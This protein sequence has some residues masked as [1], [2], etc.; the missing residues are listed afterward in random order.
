MTV[1]SILRFYRSVSVFSI[2]GFLSLYQTCSAATMPQD[3]AEGSLPKVHFLR[4]QE[5]WSVLKGIPSSQLSRHDHIKFIALDSQDRNWLSLGG[6]F[7][8]RAENWSNFAFSAPRNNDDSF[9]L[10]R[11]TGHADLH[12]GRHHRFFLEGKSALA[13]DRDLPGGKR[14]LDVDTYALQQAFWDVRLSITDNTTLTI[15]PG[16]QELLLGKQRLVSP[17]PW[18]NSLRSWDGVS[19]LIESRNWRTHGFW[20]QFSP[21][22]QYGF[23]DS[24]QDSL[25]FGLYSS[26][27]L[28]HTALDL[29]WL[30]ID[31]KQASFNGSSGSELRHTLG[32]HVSGQST[33][34]DGMDYDVEVAY[35]FGHVGRADIQAYMFASEIGH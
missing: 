32:S 9:V 13:T 28:A 27:S 15:R 17:L 25:L 1:N 14:T 10:W 34:L 4:Y 18:G 22:D 16:R 2:L 3:H 29:Y 8:V 7:R 33:I 20:T 24:D 26:R 35:Q 23:N 6:H 30:G 5:N 12:L 31:R 19:L 11:M 21:V